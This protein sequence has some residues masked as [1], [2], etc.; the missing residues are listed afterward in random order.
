MK[1]PTIRGICLWFEDMK[2][3]ILC[4]I[5][6]E[7]EDYDDNEENL[8]SLLKSH[9]DNHEQPDI[10]QCM[11]EFP[12]SQ[13]GKVDRKELK[14]LLMKS[15]KSTPTKTP[16]NIFK[17]FLKNTLGLRKELN[18][19][20][21]E[22]DTSNPKRPRITKLNGNFRYYGGTSFHALSLSTEIGALCS[23]PNDQRKILE[24][25][26]DD[27]GLISLDDIIEFLSTIESNPKIVEV[28]PLLSPRPFHIKQLWRYNLEKCIDSSPSLL[29]TDDVIAVGS[30]SQLVLIA[31]ASTGQLIAK[32]KLPDRV[33][34][35][36]VFLKEYPLAAVGCYNGHLYVF[37][38]STGHIEWSINV[39]GMI[40]AKP[41][42]FYEED[43][44]VVASYAL[45]YNLSAI[46]IKVHLPL[47]LFQ[48]II[49]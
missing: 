13:H 30:H 5:K 24:M 2:K 19:Y 38:W 20:N 43:L 18:I 7:E 34:C 40:K 8:V 21:L 4:I 42:L 44:M 22:K 49:T 14:S 36:V 47:H 32:L 39:G 10:I 46:C 25:L 12:L 11:R 35:P 45:E 23:N 6:E 1:F 16:L 48:R 27:E 37:N 26:L 33:E 17:D 41:L 29:E 15:I 28:N 9:L 31:N 3:L